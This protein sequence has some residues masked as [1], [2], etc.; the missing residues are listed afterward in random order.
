MSELAFAKSFLSA[1]DSR[2]VKLRPDYVHEPETPRAPY[3]LPRLQPPRPE[4]PKK[5]RTPAAPGSSKSISITL[6]SARN[7]VLEFTIPNAPLATTTI[8]DLK[9][10]V[11]ERT[12][13]TGS[14]NK[15]ALDKIKILY[16]RKPVTGTG[17]TVG[18]ILTDAGEGTEKE[19]EFGVM[20]MGGARVADSEGQKQEGAGGGETTVKPAVGPSGEEVLVTEQFWDDLQGYLTQRLKDEELAKKLRVVF[21]DAWAATR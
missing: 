21:G 19:V 20:V 5:T 18:E 1:L 7:P 6:K 12:L 2:P 13:E 15:V 8:S 17:K 4:M 3:L 16:K 14:E 9:G 10:A 11:R